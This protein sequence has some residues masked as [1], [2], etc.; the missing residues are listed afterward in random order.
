MRL[1]NLLVL[2]VLLSTPVVAA[3]R[4]NIVFILADD[5]G[6]SDLGCYGADLYETPNIDSLAANG[7]KFTDAYA[8]PVCSPTRAALLTGRH[9]ARVRMTIW[10][11][12]SLKGP[13]NRKLL[14]GE[15][16]HSLPHS[17]TTLAM[18]LQKAGYFTALV[19][20]WHLGDADHYPKI[21]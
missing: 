3:D 18:L 10:S 7:M 1:I 21:V 4:P 8:M 9:A 11:E 15:S 5:M 16:L 20:K 13:Q 12:G 14:Q 6:W 17:E 19:G 2:I